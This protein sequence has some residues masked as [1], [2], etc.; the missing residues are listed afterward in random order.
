MDGVNQAWQAAHPGSGPLVLGGTDDDALQWWL[1]DRSQAAAD[2]AADWLMSHPATG[3]TIDGSSRTLAHSGLRRIYAGAAAA[4]YFHVPVADPR[5]PDLWGVVQVGV[6]YTGGK[7]KI[8]EHGG[9]N[10]ADRRVPLVVYAPGTVASGIHAERVKTTEI[11]P[12]ILRLLG[13]DP[14]ALQAVR[15]EGT[16]VLPDLR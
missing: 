16:A 10:P 8:A 6:V 3:N 11:A 13:L 14:S 9:S 7:G 4:Q 1:T 15:E 2:F 5:H 12:T